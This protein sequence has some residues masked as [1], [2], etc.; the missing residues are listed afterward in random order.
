VTTQTVPVLS[1]RRHHRRSKT[2]QDIHAT[3]IHGMSQTRLACCCT[4]RHG[5]F[6]SRARDNSARRC[7][8]TRRG[9][10][11]SLQWL[12]RTA[13]RPLARRR[14]TFRAY[15]LQQQVST[16]L[17]RPIRRHPRRLPQ[18]KTT[19]MSSHGWVWPPKRLAS[20]ASPSGASA[21]RTR[22]SRRS[23]CS[24]TSTLAR[25]AGRPTATTRRTCVWRTGGCATTMKPSPCGSAPLIL[26]AERVPQ[27]AS[28]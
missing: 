11:A 10:L 17:L 9:C 25:W 1:L 18:R 12:G 28:V 16:G 8:C 4:C 6:H 15:L 23:G 5:A 14:L 20:A 27:Q 22:S 3:R 19:L 21:R 26:H 13:R 24:T 2:Q 7:R